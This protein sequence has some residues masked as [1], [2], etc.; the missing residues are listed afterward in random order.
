[1]LIAQLSDL[2]LR[3]E[4]DP[5]YVGID[6]PACA[7]AAVAAIAALDPAPDCVLLTGDLTDGSHDEEFA[8]LRDLLRPLRM[9]C[10]LIT[11][12]HDEAGSLRR[13]FADHRYLGD[14][15]PLNWVI[16]THPLRLIA[17]DTVV[18]R[19]SHGS[20]PTDT[21]V[22]LDRQLAASA[23][24]TIIVMHHPPFATGLAG[25]DAIGVR[26]GANELEAIVRR[27]P[28]IERLLCGHLHR[29]IF[30]RFGGSVVSVCPSTAHQITLDLQPDAAESYVLE[31]PGYQLHL[32]RDGEGLVTHHAVIGD[33]AGP[34]P[35]DD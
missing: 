7:R 28:Q 11:G 8:L 1:M 25:M 32:W 6:T 17:I 14:S 33:Y 15:G 19:A 4:G 29:T 3:R 21:L 30:R 24:P 13:T 31:P 22:W 10:Y 35:F 18:P 20:L 16:D 12:N 2:H 26:Q 5:A 23:R 9:P 34:F 27:H